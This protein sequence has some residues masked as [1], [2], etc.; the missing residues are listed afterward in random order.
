MD[1]KAEEQLKA[2]ERC[3]MAR[4]HFTFELHSVLLQLQSFKRKTLFE[5]FELALNAV[6]KIILLEG[7]VIQD[8]L[9]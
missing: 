5:N 7:Q 6:L 3:C 1:E 8:K 9:V 2:S 4:S